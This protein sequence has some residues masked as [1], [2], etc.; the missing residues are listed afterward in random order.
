MQGYMFNAVSMDDN[1]SNTPGEAKAN[2]NSRS[3]FVEYMQ[4]YVELEP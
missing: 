3:N 4:R 1:R 2:Q